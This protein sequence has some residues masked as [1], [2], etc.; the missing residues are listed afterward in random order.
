MAL[1]YQAQLTPGKIELLRA[2]MPAQQWWAGDG[3]TIDVVGAYRFDDP[4]GEVGIETHLLRVGD[5]HT[6]QVPLT[7][8]GAPLADAEGALVGTMQ[9]SVLGARWVYDGCFDQ[10][11]AAALATTIL[12]GGTQAELQI[13]SDGPPEHREPTARVVGSGTPDVR[14]PTLGAMSCTNDA[15]RTTIRAGELELVVRRTLSADMIADAAG[16]PNGTSTGTLT[17]TWPGNLEPT[18]LALARVG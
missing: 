14:V 8:R 3:A 1:L 2:W 11:Y 9:H 16:T 17:G 10:V 18:V 15:T 5:G 13:A 7:Y 4:A 6:V 12:T